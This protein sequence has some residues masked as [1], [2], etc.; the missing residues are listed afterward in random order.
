[1]AHAHDPDAALVAAEAL[2]AQAGESFTPVR[3]RVLQI[4]LAQKGPTGA[5]EL[6]DM[7][8]ADQ[9]SAKPPT[10]YRALDFLVRVGLA[11]RIESLNAFVACD[12]GHAHA[13]PVFLICDGCK[14]AFEVDAGHALHDL[15]EA[16]TQAGFRVTRTMIEAHGLCAGCRQAV[17]APQ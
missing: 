11:H 4:L 13:P 3:R 12:V 8:R 6:L 16:A 7:L 15:A 9:P 14:R 17:R 10:I 2:C 1:M 5:Y